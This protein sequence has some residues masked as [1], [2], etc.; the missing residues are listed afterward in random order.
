MCAC[1]NSHER[2]ER[3][4]Q[5][6]DDSQGKV[7]PHHVIFEKAEEI[8]GGPSFARDPERGDDDKESGDVQDGDNTLNKWKLPGDECVKKQTKCEYEPDQHR[9]LPRF[10]V[11]GGVVQLDESSY[12]LFGQLRDTCSCCLPSKY[13]KPTDHI[14][15]GS[16]ATTRCKFTDPLVFSTSSWSSRHII[17]RYVP[18]RLSAD[19]R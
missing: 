13:S 2:A 1:F 19:L 8:R 6:Y 18:L 12:L 16:L 5:A 7:T 14:A 10:H 3:S 15:Q 11:V 9:T 4:G 17:I